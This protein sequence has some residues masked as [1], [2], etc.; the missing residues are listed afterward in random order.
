AALER[1]YETFDSLMAGIQPDSHFWLTGR[2]VRALQLGGDREWAAVEADLRKAPEREIATVGGHALF[3]V[4]DAAAAARALD[5]LVEPS[6]SVEIRTIGH[7]MYA[8]LHMAG[9][10]W[11]AASASLDSARTLDPVGVVGHAGLLHAMPLLPI[12][13]AQLQKVH[14]AIA[15]TTPGRTLDSGIQSYAGDDT[16][17]AAIREYTLGL[18]DARLGRMDEARRRA[19]ALERI[20]RDSAPGMADAFAATIRAQVHLAAGAAARADAELNGTRWMPRSRAILTFSP[21]LGLRHE[22]FLRAEALDRLGRHEQALGWL[23][24]FAEHS[25]SGRIY[26][27][28]AHFRRGEILERLGRGKEAAAAYQRFVALWDRADP[29][30]QVLVTEARRRIAQLTSEVSGRQR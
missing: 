26:L 17:Q 6:R 1:D 15:A 3:L 10:R 19:A 9:G 24:S 7:L 4:E 12:P 5:L 23:A 8:H 21:L 22:R 16:L 29:E 18:L 14:A 25:A 11:R 13:A 2:M 30:F 27:A 28:P 20:G